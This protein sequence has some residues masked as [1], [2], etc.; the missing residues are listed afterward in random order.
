MS[1]TTSAAV[2]TGVVAVVVALWAWSRGRTSA[3][4]GVT[5]TAPQ[6]EP[7]VDSLVD[8]LVDTSAAIITEG[9]EGDAE[10]IEEAATSPQ[11][12]AELAKLRRGRR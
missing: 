3:G 2:A 6:A 8:S 11:S 5:T 7:S 12:A 9:A 1:A 10:M 4:P